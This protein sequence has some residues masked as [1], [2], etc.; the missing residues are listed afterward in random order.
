MAY[1]TASNS[2]NGMCDRFSFCAGV[3]D[4]RF[5]SRASIDGDRILFPLEAT[6]VAMAWPRIPL[7]VIPIPKPLAPVGHQRCHGKDMA[8]QEG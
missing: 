3:N 8:L 2:I 4:T 1:A 6:V 5:E 7:Q